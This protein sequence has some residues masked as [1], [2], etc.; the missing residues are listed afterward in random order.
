[1]GKNINI[2]A[3]TDITLSLE[4][5]SL[6]ATASSTSTKPNDFKTFEYRFIQTNTGNTDFWSL[7]IVNNNI[8]VV[9]SRTSARLNLTD[10][11][12]PR[13]SDA[14]ITY[15]VACRAVDN[16]NNYSNTSIVASILL[17]TL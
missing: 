11:S 6:V 10:F 7:N 2:Y 1:V 3:A 16:D 17:K 5:I 13:L 8:K 12:K 15:T 9:Q 4:G 14:G